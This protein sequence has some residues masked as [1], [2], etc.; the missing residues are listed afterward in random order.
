MHPAPRKH[1]QRKPPPSWEDYSGVGGGKCKPISNKVFWRLR[2]YTTSQSKES[3]TV[4]LTAWEEE[5]ETEHLWEN[6]RK[7]GTSV[8]PERW[9]SVCWAQ[10][11]GE[12][13]SRQKEYCEQRHTA[14][15]GPLRTEGEG[16]QEEEKDTQ[17]PGYSKSVRGRLLADKYKTSN[18]D[19]EK[20]RQP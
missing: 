1:G 12:W 5:E 18:A 9:I 20:E 6:S 3:S 2:M 4:N 11:S 13:H 16:L 7:E 19:W 8:S 14:P 10:G 15:L 17:D